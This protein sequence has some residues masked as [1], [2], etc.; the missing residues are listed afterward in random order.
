M[1][2]LRVLAV[3]HQ[4]L[5]P[6]RDP[7][8][9]HTDADWK[10]E[11]DVIESLETLGHDV[12]VVG[13]RSRLD[14]LSKAVDAFRPHVLF[15]LLEDFDGIAVNDQHWVS[16]LE[17]LGIP[18]TGCNPRGLL[19]ARDKAISKTLLAHEGIRVP[20]FAVCT[21]GEGVEVPT[22]LEFPVIVKSL[23]FDGSVGISQ[24]SVVTTKRKL[25]ERVAFVHSE[26]GTDA[27]V[28]EY[29]DGRELYVGVIGNDR[30]TTFPV[31][32]LR[33]KK[34]PRSTRLVA[35]E[36]VKWSNKYQ[37]KLGVV[38]GKARLPD[39]RAR[40][41]QSLAKRVYR[42][43]K[44]SG[45]ARIDFRM[46]ARGDVYFLEANPNPQL[47]YGEDFAESGESGGLSY[48]ALM[49]RIVELGLGRRR[50]G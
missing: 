38:T 24:A 37:Q 13:L 39:T 36:R 42:I 30:L 45:Y 44:M 9:Y 43:L 16:H 23:I 35:T 20:G 2:R 18:Y 21:R 32:E 41:I 5:L 29:V 3:V 25:Q 26:V 22:D 49:Q 7:A 11:Y 28:E 15:N 31:W 12:E 6:P 33:F 40:E 48:E 50:R 1:R 27:I 46:D 47:A 4:E 8:R 14:V 10:M 17:L 19:L 34:R